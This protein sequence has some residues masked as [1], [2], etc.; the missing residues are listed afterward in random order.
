MSDPRDVRYVTGDSR[1][2]QFWQHLP[3][4]TQVKS[5]INVQSVARG[6]HS[7][8]AW[9]DTQEFTRVSGPT[10][11]HSVASSLKKHLRVRNAA[12][13]LEERNNSQYT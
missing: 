4:S 2:S 9:Q 11:V 1:I 8:E 10:S 6:L 7:R 12:R 13:G 3:G 5:P